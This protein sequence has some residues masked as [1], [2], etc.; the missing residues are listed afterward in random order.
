M[1]AIPIPFVVSLLLA[2]LAIALYVRFAE[3]AKTACWFLILCALTTGLVGLRWSFNLPLF[4]LLQPLFA[5]CIPVF[6]WYAFTHLSHTQ[7]LTQFAAKHAAGPLLVLVS[8]TIQPHWYLPL[9]EILTAI[10]LVYGIALVRYSAK[11]TVLIHVSLSSWES[12]KR[13]EN[14]AGW[15]LLFSALIDGAMS[16]DFTYNQGALAPF[17][18]SIGHLV[19]LPV[20]SLAVILVAINTANHDE[21]DE[22]SDKESKLEAPLNSVSSLSAQQAQTIVIALDELMKTK[23]AYLDPELTLSKLSRKLCVPAKQISSAVN[24]VKQKNISRVINEYRIEHAKQALHSSDAPITQIFMN[25]G[26]QTKSNFNREFSRL[27]GMTP[28]QYR[29]TATL[30]E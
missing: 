9:D 10:Y 5:S 22:L 28:S 18:L 6:A 21:A 11:E 1:L 17:I 26:F 12:V 19:L 13:S 2:L 24:Q 8:V 25:C 23:H 27:T 3:Q 4:A 14:I 15:M 20:L 7:T 30:A 29:K 16:L